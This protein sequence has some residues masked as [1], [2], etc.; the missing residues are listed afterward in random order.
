M[1]I[2]VAYFMVVNDAQIINTLESVPVECTLVSFTWTYSLYVIRS[3]VLRITQSHVKVY[4]TSGCFHI[5]TGDVVEIKDY[6]FFRRKSQS[7]FL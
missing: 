5:F 3:S 7:Q 2:I 6:G 1:K 4:R